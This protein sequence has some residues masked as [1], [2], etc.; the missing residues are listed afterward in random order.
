MTNDDD[1]VTAAAPTTALAR[2]ARPRPAPRWLLVLSRSVLGVA[3]TVTGV[4]GVGVAT[5]ATPMLSMVAGPQARLAVP[6][7]APPVVPVLG[8]PP[9]VEAT[10]TDTSETTTRTTT[11]SPRRTVDDETTTVR[12]TTRPAPVVP[13]VPEPEPVAP[14]PVEPS[15]G[16]GGNGRGGQNGGGGGQ[17]GA[18]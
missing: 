1:A 3:A 2:P 4:L 9:S 11:R 12:R 7:P 18:G 6:V 16:G 13:V 10:T 14:A 8:P 17:N 5:G 15:A